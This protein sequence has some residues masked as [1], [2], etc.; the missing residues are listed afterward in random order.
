MRKNGSCPQIL[1]HVYI[2]KRNER[3][4]AFSDWSLNQRKTAQINRRVTNVR[5]I[6]DQQE[7]DQRNKTAQINRRVTKSQTAKINRRVTNVTNVTNR[8]VTNVTNS[9]D[10]QEVTNLTNSVDQQKGDQRHKRRRS[11]GV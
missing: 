3:E 2:Y 5:D 6:T 4:R 10:Q 1:T 9:A 11:T 7:G 8:R